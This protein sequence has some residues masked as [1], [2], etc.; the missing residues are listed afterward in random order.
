MGEEGRILITGASGYVGGRLKLALNGQ[1]KKLRLLVRSPSFVSERQGDG[2]Q[3]EVGDARDKRVLM[4]ALTGIESAYYF[5]HSMSS[6][7]DFCTEDRELAAQFARTASKCG[8]KRIIYLGGLGSHCE[9][10]SSHLKSRQE[11]GEILRANAEGVQ[12][13]EFRASIVL[14]SGSLS[15]EMVRALTEKLPVMITPKWVWTEAQPIAIDDLLQY[16]VQSLTLEFNGNPIFEIGGKDRVS[17]GGL[18]LEYARQRKLKRWVIPVPVL[19]PKLSSLWLGLVTPLYARVGRKLIES[20]TCTTVVH[21]PLAMHLFGIHP[22]GYREAIALA[23]KNEGKEAPETRWNESIS[24]SLL[25]SDW[26]KEALGGRLLDQREKIV[27]CSPEEAFKPIESIGGSQ[28]YYCCTWLW[29]LRGLFDLLVG[30]V[31]FRRGRRDPIALKAGEVVDFWRVEEIKAPHF[32]RLRAEMKVPGKAWLEFYVEPLS[33]GTKI[34]QRAVFEPAGIFGM[35]YWY[36]LY[37]IHHV[38]FGGLLRGIV[39]RIGS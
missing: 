39:N 20:A 25:Q 6:I 35:I 17:Y 38:V 3:Y 5:I 1:G 37:P 14:G 11:V 8:V 36:L 33:G 30:G 7:G 9:E 13:I 24:S 34:T 28:G 16:L 31:G 10:L 29:R 27:P 18:M 26:P 22:M 12:V 19:S 15:F 2:I 21:D 32:L 4:R 23:L